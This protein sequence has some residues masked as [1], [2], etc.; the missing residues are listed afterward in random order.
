MS[1][2]LRTTSESMTPAQLDTE[3]Y[4]EAMQCLLPVAVICGLCLLA[5]VIWVTT[6]GHYAGSHRNQALNHAVIR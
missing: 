4:C 2:W 1:P 5:T 6:I 3:F